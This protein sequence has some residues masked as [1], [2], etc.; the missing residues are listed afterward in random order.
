MFCS[1]GKQNS[2]AWPESLTFDIK[3]RLE[4]NNLNVKRNTCMCYVLQK[5]ILGVFYLTGLDLSHTNQPAP[6]ATNDKNLVTKF[7]CTAA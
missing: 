6:G 2:L 5:L 7:G 4:K 1:V 3:T